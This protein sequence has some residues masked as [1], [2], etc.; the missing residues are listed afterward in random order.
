MIVVNT[1]LLRAMSPYDASGRPR[2]GQRHAHRP[3]RAPR[4]KARAS[5]GSLVT[6][7]WRKLRALHLSMPGPRI[8]SD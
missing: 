1:D 2:P 4:R 6:L 5:S 7:A 8:T 3:P